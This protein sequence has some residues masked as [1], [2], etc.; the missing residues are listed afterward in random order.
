MARRRPKIITVSEMTHVEA[1]DC[2]DVRGRCRCDWCKK[3]ATHFVRQSVSRPGF[4]MAIAP[5]CVACM[6][7]HEPTVEAKS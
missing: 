1:M 6:G 3:P 2:H 5:K 4:H 7:L